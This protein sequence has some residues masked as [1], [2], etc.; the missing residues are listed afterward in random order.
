M[1][2]KV[3]ICDD[4]PAFIKSLRDSIYEV[5]SSVNQFQTE[6]SSGANKFQI[7]VSSATNTLDARRMIE[8]GDFDLI[9]LDT[10]LSEDGNVTYYDYMSSRLLRPQHGPALVEDIHRYCE[11]ARIMVVS[12]N[13]TQYSR[14][15]FKYL[16]AEYFCKGDMPAPKIA[17]QV[18]TYFT[19]NK[20]RFLNNVFVVYGHNSEMHTS[21]L[22][23][24]HELQLNIIDLHASSHS[25]ISSVLDLLVDC[26]IV[27]L[28]GDDRAICYDEER[29]FE[30]LRYRARQNVIFEMGLFTG[31][32][33]RD[34]VIALYEKMPA[35]EFPSDI[36]AMFFAEY[37]EGMR[38]KKD[39]K[40]RLNKIGFKLK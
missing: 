38:W 18:V 31:L 29:G 16:D 15:E 35:F 2:Y 9:V 14:I 8:G 26:A 21:V 12:N 24:L 36:T 13:P 33:G 22:K 30:T 32:L 19:T 34:K 6:G 40:N 7:D 5:S 39:L 10:T 1:T 27:L 3:L 11:H 25:G 4:N 37:D 28:S 20:K 17:R 23:Y